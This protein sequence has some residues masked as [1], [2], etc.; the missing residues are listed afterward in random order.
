MIVIRAVFG[1]CADVTGGPA[2]RRKCPKSVWRA[3]I[4]R[5]KSGVSKRNEG[6]DTHP[7]LLQPHQN[8]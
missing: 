2:R 4:S 3:A 5:E 8:R 7:A 1:R 6:T